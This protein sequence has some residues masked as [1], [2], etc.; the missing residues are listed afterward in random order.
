M[1]AREN[2]VSE[3]RN[4]YKVGYYTRLEQNLQQLE[5]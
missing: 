4:K 5:P 2:C 3:Y 1:D